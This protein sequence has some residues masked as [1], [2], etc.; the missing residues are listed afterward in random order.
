MRHFVAW[1]LAG[2]VCLGISAS[3]RAQGA[4]QPRPEEVFQRTYFFERE[5]RDR[6]E[7][8]VPSKQAALIEYGGFYI[9]SY[10]EYTDIDD[11]MAHVTRQDMRLWMQAQFDDIHRVFARLKF[12]YTDYAA[13]DA[14]GFRSHDFNGPDLDIGYYELDLSGAMEK[15]FDQTWPARIK[16][17]G[18]RQF[19]EVGRGIALSDTLDVGSFDVETKDL[20]FTAFA[21]RTPTGR[22]DIDR[23]MP[24][25]DHTRRTF[26]GMEARY[27]GIERHE[28]YYFLVWQ[29]DWSNEK[30][31][32]PNQ[33]YRYSSHYHGIGSRGE[34]CPNLLYNLENIWEFGRSSANGQEGDREHIRGYAFDSQLDYYVPCDLKPILSVEYAYAS[35]DGDRQSAT[36]STLGN[37]IGTHDT[38]FLGFGYINSGLALGSRFT[39]LQFVRLGGRITAYENKATFGRIDLGVNLY[40]QYKTDHDGPISDARAT[41]TSSNIG[42]EVDT[43]VEWRILSDLALSVHYGRF[44]PGAAYVNGDARDFLF[45]AL[46]FSF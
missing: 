43:Y 20:L 6:L 5:I 26:Y 29:R 44:K 40:F 13:G 41:T 12:D 18:G 11:G 21:G 34:V 4:A 31:D 27:R 3:V 8:D 42:K 14:H 22:E 17:R 30:P 7:Q 9:P 45:T 15:Y 16:I 35:G 28:P 46:T 1:I 2:A 32:N 10:A 33:D 37:T 38:A 25:Y 19:V 39:N 36:T 24:G 23:S